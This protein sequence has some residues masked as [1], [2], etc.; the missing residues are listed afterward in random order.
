MHEC[1]C[2]CMCVCLCV[3]G[4]GESATG[5]VARDTLV[6]GSRR[7]AET[8]PH[9]KRLLPRADLSTFLRD[10]HRYAA[11]PT[12]SATGRRHIG[13]GSFFGT[14]DRRASRCD[15]HESY[16]LRRRQSPNAQGHWGIPPEARPDPPCG[17]NHS[18]RRST[19][20]LVVHHKRWNRTRCRQASARSAHL[21]QI[22]PKSR[23]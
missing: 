22:A 3:G 11:A 4:G 8:K 13:V 5:R 12:R 6:C 1:M 23:A 15:R 21:P 9:R 17:R 19:A 18:N 7:A 10:W 20:L 2:A 16:R 14:A